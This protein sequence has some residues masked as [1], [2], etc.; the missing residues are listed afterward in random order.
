MK[1]HEKQNNTLFV[2]ATEAGQKLLQFL[3]RRLGLST[4]ILH[5][6]I[7]T[8]QIR[9]QGG[10]C[11]AFRR[12]KE[13]E[14]VRLPPFA[15]SMAQSTTQSANMLGDAQAGD[16]SGADVLH[17]AVPQETSQKTA[18]EPLASP[19]LDLAS[20]LVHDD[21]H[22]LVFN[23]PAGLPV[24]TGTGHTDSLATRL[25]YAYADDIFRPTPIHR[26]DKDTSG[27]ILVARSYAALRAVQ[28]ILKTRTL[29]KEYLAWVHGRWPHEREE[30]ELTHF[31]KKKYDGDDEK[32]RVLRHDEGKQATCLV[33][34]LRRHSEAERGI[35]G[36]ISLVRVKLISGRTHQI[37]VQLAAE[38]FPV[39]GDVKYGAPPLGHALCLHAV[40]VTLPREES[41][42]S[43]HL[44]AH[45][46]SALP[47]W[48]G[49]L[50][51]GNILMDI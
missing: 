40:R 9:V 34:C 15:L 51:V 29:T 22:L 24:H 31:I 4:S 2:H 12:L 21:A 37:R 28:D 19:M 33:T 50:A 10:R 6:W 39:V 35:E 49:R 17:Q 13:G 1:I 38:G 46:F 45:T 16:S 26:L 48:S 32:V 8:G 23:K 36:G 47:P 42:E 18:L 41:I 44:Q 5:K 11:D 3:V 14:A 30:C 7:R 25:E 20:Y 43:L 27:I